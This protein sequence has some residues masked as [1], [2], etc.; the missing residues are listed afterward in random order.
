[1][2]KY[3][4]KGIRIRKCDIFKKLTRNLIDR[5]LLIDGDIPT[6]Q[7]NR[8]NVN[9]DRLG[10]ENLKFWK[11]ANVNKM[12]FSLHYCN[13]LIIR[14]QMNIVLNNGNYYDEYILCFA[15]DP[16]VEKLNRLKFRGML[17]WFCFFLEIRKSIVSNTWHTIYWLRT[18]TFESKRPNLY[19]SNWQK[20]FSN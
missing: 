20:T 16:L 15:L 2:F 19:N 7:L 4:P 11:F 12:C 3:P 13:S 14:S 10:I 9:T 1:M 6:A 17:S 5:S 18:K 8:E